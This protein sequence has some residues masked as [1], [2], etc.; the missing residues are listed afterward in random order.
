MFT[1]L[2]AAAA[3][4]IAVSDALSN[5]RLRF[6]IEVQSQTSDCIRIISTKP[7]AVGNFYFAKEKLD[8]L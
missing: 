5:G 6:T 1:L 3:A 7:F 8:I 2:Y 4:S